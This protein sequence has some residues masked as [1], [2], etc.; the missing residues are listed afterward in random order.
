MEEI[1]QGQGQEECAVQLKKSEKIKQTSQQKFKRRKK[2]SRHP[3]KSLPGRRKSQVWGCGY[4]SGPGTRC[5]ALTYTISKDH[6]GHSAENRLWSSKSREST[7]VIQMGGGVHGPLVK[8][9][10]LQG[11]EKCA[12]SG[13]FW[14]KKQWGSLTDWELEKKKRTV[15]CLRGQAEG[16]ELPSIETRRLRRE[17]FTPE[18]LWDCQE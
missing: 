4:R 17:M 16:M 8:G 7:M 3:A 1:K 9:S 10:S 2:A 5:L 18:K 12:I 11:G 13:L 15:R 6:S 14:R